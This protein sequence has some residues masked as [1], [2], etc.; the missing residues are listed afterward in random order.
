MRLYEPQ[1]ANKGRHIVRA[2]GISGK[3]GPNI[4]PTQIHSGGEYDSHII[5]PFIN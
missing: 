2:L 5:L 1:D 4:I 3:R